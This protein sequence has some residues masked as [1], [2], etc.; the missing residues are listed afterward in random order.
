MIASVSLLESNLKVR[1]LW[2]LLG[3]AWLLLGMVQGTLGYILTYIHNIQTVVVGCNTGKQA[4]S[5][6]Y[7]AVNSVNFYGGVCVYYIPTIL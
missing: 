6:N 7:P 1:G 5:Y 4:N 2:R 3:A